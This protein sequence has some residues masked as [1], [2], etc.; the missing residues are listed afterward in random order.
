MKKLI[1]LVSLIALLASGMAFAQVTFN[2]KVE[3]EVANDFDSGTGP[4]GV[5]K[6]DPDVR[7]EMNI[8]AD[9]FNSAHIR[10]RL[11]DTGMGFNAGTTDATTPAARYVYFD[12]AFFTTDVLGALEVKNA[13][14]K[15]ISQIGLNE[16]YYAN[17]ALAGWDI[18]NAV[19]LRTPAG[20]Y[21]GY[22]FDEKIWG[23]RQAFTFSD[24]FTVAAF[25]GLQYD[26]L[27]DM[28]VDA[29]MTMPAGAG[30]LSAE[31]AYLLWE[32]AA[33]SFD[34]GTVKSDLG[35]GTLMPAAGYDFKAGD[36][37]MKAGA[38]YYHAL[39][40]ENAT[41]ALAANV[42]ATIGAGYVL[43][44]FQGFM[45]NDDLG[46]Y[47]GE[48]LHNVRLAAG[49]ALNKFLQADL[50]VI[51]YTGGEDSIGGDNE[52]LNTLDASLCVKAG[53]ASFRFGYMMVPEN[54][55]SIDPLFIDNNKNAF[56]LLATM[57]Y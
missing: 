11:N 21:N 52:T 47:E 51:L 15:W 35:Q 10:M 34:I 31:V 4:A 43:A 22:Y 3:V 30:K 49:Y 24:M 19:L 50:G 36:I 7:I 20:K 57:A 14:V 33:R 13:P 44:G 39:E 55:V 46:P 54:D 6:W 16:W 18:T 2:G 42:K 25:F 28:Y 26:R 29:V 56:Y 37:P 1:I 38:S 27:Q 53:K 8:K 17:V 32:N 48:I 23:T 9:N 40:T 45:E 12:K 41:S 5:E